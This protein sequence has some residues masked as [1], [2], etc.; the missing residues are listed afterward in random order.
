MTR[1]ITDRV[2]GCLVGGA[3]GDALGAPVENWPYDRIREEYGKVESFRAYDNPHAK[4]EPGT[5]TDDTVMSHYLCLAIVEKGGRVTP[6]EYADVLRKYLNP[7]RVWVTE[8][9]VIR[10]L[11]AGINPRDAGRGNIPTGTATMS[12]AP[13]GI[14]NAANPRQAYQDGVNIASVNQD[15]VNRDAAATVAAGVAEAFSPNASIDSVIETML[16]HSSDTVF[17]A[18]DLALGLVEENETIDEFVEQFYDRFLDWRWPAVEWDREMYYQG[19]VFSADS[20]ELLPAVIGILA[21][22]DGD[23]NQSLVEAAS[24]GRDCDTI[25]SVT[26]NIVGALRGASSLRD[27][28]IEDCEAANTEFLKE[29]HRT[30]DVDFET[31]SEWLVNALED[32]REWSKQ[33]TES[34]DTIL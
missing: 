22:C 24:F 18:L 19:R 20:I 21:L 30:D 33:R 4:G 8:E 27:D 26:G 7:D 28:W 12:I 9:I 25:A 10:K 34:L 29:V 14:I 13:V 1:P 6:D 2:Y 23:V 15:G 3:I 32:E 5:V 16:E 11:A 31:M 17:R